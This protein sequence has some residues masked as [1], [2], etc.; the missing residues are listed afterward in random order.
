MKHLKT[1][2]IV[3]LVVCCATSVQA[4]DLVTTAAVEIV[5]GISIAQ[6][7]GMD[8]GQ[9]ADHDGALVL[10]TNPASPMTD[11]SFISFDPT[12]YTPGIFTVNSIIGASVNASFVDAADVPGLALSAWTV[13]LDGGSSDEGDL[14]AITQ[15]AAADTWNIGATLTVTA[16]TASIGAATPGY[17]ITVVLN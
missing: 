14:T 2:T 17:T 13:S 7:T 15:V 9:V 6:T 16:A 5:E 1:L 10:A 12:G 11:A 4:F 8:F 3:A